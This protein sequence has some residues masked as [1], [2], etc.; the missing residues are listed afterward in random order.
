MDK[1][2][3]FIQTTDTHLAV[4]MVRLLHEHGINGFWVT[5]EEARKLSQEWNVDAR[6]ELLSEVVDR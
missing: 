3:V 6:G 4:R 1:P 5:S 2:I